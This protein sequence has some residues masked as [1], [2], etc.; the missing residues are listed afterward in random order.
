MGGRKREYI[1]R[2]KSDGDMW[3]RRK[4]DVIGV[5]IGRRDGTGW[6]QVSNTSDEGGSPTSAD[7]KG[8]GQ[9]PTK[10]QPTGRVGGRRRRTDS[11]SCT[12]DCGTVA[13]AVTLKEH[14]RRHGR[15]VR[16]LWGGLLHPHWHSCRAPGTPPLAPK[17]KRVTAW[18][19]PKAQPQRTV[20]QSLSGD[21]DGSSRKS[22]HMPPPGQ[23]G[24]LPVAALRSRVVAPSTTAL[25]PLVPGPPA[26]H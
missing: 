10:S 4:E 5:Q 13:K 17:C 15:R 7:S 22:S 11:S 2:G 24:T 8:M 12:A 1:G 19:L 3:R 26:D 25:R 21:P 23:P 6:G 9:Y 20:Q 16:G 18:G 14:S